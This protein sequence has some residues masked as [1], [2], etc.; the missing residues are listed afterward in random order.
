M[1]NPFRDMSAEEAAAHIESLLDIP[2]DS[3]RPKGKK[4]SEVDMMDG[5]LEV[6][7]H[8]PSWIGADGWPLSWS[9]YQYALRH[10]AR[11]EARDVLGVA[12]ASRT[13]F[14]ADKDGW[15]RFE[16]ELN[17]VAGRS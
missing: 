7:R 10:L 17:A 15:Q 14:N 5:L 9:H 8:F 3:L 13:A 6:V 2:D 1:F 4:P 16:R 12:V 11:I